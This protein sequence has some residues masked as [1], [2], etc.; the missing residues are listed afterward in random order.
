ME[1]KYLN[2]IKCPDDVKKLNI[3]ELNI[4][5]SEMRETLIQ[6]LSTH[7]GHIGPN[8]GFVEATAAMHYVFNSPVDKMVFDVSHQSYCHKMLTGRAEAFLDSAHYDDVSGYSEPSE[9][10]H[11]LFTVGH[12]S[13]SLSLAAGLARARDL[14]GGK[15]NVIAVIGDG[16]LS[17]GEALEALDYIGEQNTNLI[18]IVNDN[19]MSIAENHG[20]IYKNL[21]L[22]RKTNGTAECNMFKAFGLDYLYV[23]NGND[24]SSLIN[25]FQKVKNT[26]HS[27]VVHIHTKKGKGLSFAENDPESYHAGGPFDK[28]TGKYLYES[29]EEDYS[30]II[31]KY[32]L[33]KMKSDPTVVA[34]NAATPVVM[35]M[36]KERRIIAGKQFIDVGIAEEN[37]AAMASGIAKRGG[38]PIWGAYSTFIQRTYDQIS[39]D[40]CINQSP[41]TILTFGASVNYMNDVTHLGFYDIPMLSN[42]PNLVY[43]APTTAEELMAMLDWSIEQTKYPVAIRVPVEVIHT[44]EAVQKDYSELNRF[45]VAMNGSDIAVIA[46]GSFFTLGERLAAKIEEEK[47]TAPTLINPRYLTGIDEEFLTMLKEKHNKVITLEDGILDGGFGE[48]IARFYGSSDMK[49]YNFGLKKEFLDRYNAEEIMKKNHLSPEQ[50]LEDINK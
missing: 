41:V 46:V 8:L 18:I 12:T 31:G 37:A 50:I 39:Q 20:G 43:L 21:E 2:K 3:N 15:E 33:E 6:K 16:S 26:D 40:I 49:V 11:D 30:D 32:L 24:V 48:K 10:E 5:A 35:G 47:G 1:I 22:L 19:E 28:V 45:K 17:G 4:L 27:V 14:I 38:K 36:T 29:Q 34:I 25:A 23:E 42:I 44:K 13:T 9:S 7:G